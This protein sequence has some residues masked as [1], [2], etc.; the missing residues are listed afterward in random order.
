MPLS[1]H[2][3]GVFRPVAL[4]L[5]RPFG[6]PETV[7][8][9]RRMKDFRNLRAAELEG[10]AQG[11]SLKDLSRHKSTGKAKPRKQPRLNRMIAFLMD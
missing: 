7:S 1:L 9:L 11:P 4:G 5:E 3:V 6:E 8:E 10:Q 2:A